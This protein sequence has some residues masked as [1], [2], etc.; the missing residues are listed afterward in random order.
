MHTPS[1]NLLVNFYCVPS[2]RLQPSQDLPSFCE[3]SHG[4][5]ED[6]KISQDLLQIHHQTRGVHR[7]RRL[8]IVQ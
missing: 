2:F 1:I 8:M 6:K 5:K 4:K 3:K 7:E